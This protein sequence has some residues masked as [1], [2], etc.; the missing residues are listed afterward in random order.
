MEHDA[1]QALSDAI[2]TNAE[3]VLAEEKEEDTLDDWLVT[4][5]E[6]PKIIR[7]SGKF[8]TKKWKKL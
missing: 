7:Y 8:L 1:L 4:D 6:E 2:A 5:D 3:Y